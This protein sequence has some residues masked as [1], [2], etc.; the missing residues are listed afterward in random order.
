MATR[1][2]CTFW[3]ED[4][5]FGLDVESVQEVLR[6]QEMTHV[7][8]ASPAIQGLINLRGQIVTAV[9]LRRCLDLPPSASSEPAMN[10]IMQS[11][12]SLVSLMVDRIGDVET[13]DDGTFDAVP[14]TLDANTK[15]IV[16][17]VCKLKGRLLLVLDPRGVLAKITRG[18]GPGGG[19]RD[20]HVN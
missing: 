9:D 20:S 19:G 10:V 4:I 7:P 14:E 3:I 18:C 11:A 2:I 1:Q 8:L 12:G 16:R 5:A 6:T 15:R 17:S 13:V